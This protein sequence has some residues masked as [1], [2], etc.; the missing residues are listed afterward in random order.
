MFLAR[1]D[2]YPLAQMIDV[3]SGRTRADLVLKNANVVNVFTGDITEGDNNT[4]DDAVFLHWWDYGYWVIS[5][6]MAP[7]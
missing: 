7:I 2:D 6:F 3:A 1:S 5:L 4:P